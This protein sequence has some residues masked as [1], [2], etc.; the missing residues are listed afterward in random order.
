MTGKSMKSIRIL[1]FFFVL[2]LAVRIG[3]A[4]A[5]A[6]DP[7]LLKQLPGQWTCD[8][9]MGET[10]DEQETKAPAL[11]FL[12][13]EEDGAMSLRFCGK[14]GEYAYSCDGTWACEIVPD[15]N[16]RLTL[17]FTST[18]N[19]EQ[20]GNEYNVECVFEAYTESWVE[21][22]TLNMYLI[23]TE[24]SSNGASPF[25]ALAG[26]GYFEISL[27]REQGPNMQVV[28]CKDYVS[29]REK[30]TTSSK[31]LARVPLGALVLAYPETEENG[32]I[33][34]V[35][36]GQEGYILSAYLQAAY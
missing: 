26:P 9:Y 33:R 11:A 16:D 6:G 20:A 8:D 35:Y 3:A 28:N 23:L 32:F 5:Y 17:Q 34:C 27:H 2:F 25:G 15:L 31:R 7:E 12:T 14:D 13:L 1:L 19:P 10:A 24:I 4:D 30:R 18:D 21:N 36:Q 22:D 29:L